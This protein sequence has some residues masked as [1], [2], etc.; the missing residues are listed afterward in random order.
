MLASAVCARIKWHDAHFTDQETKA[1]KCN[2]LF[3]TYHQEMAALGFQS[4]ASPDCAGRV[5]GHLQATP[6]RFS[7]CYVNY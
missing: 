6:S 3:K 7:S 5:R 2:D 4:G 1:L